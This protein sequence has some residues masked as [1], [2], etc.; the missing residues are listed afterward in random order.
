MLLLERSSTTNKILLPSKK[1]IIAQLIYKYDS[2]L[3]IYGSNPFL[4]KIIK[5]IVI[6][7]LL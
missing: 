1:T 7:S 2:D 3:E 4:S 6:V 5:V